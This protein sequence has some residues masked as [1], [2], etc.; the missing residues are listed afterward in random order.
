MRCSCKFRKWPNFGKI[1]IIMVAW[2]N[3]AW[4]NMFQQM[5]E[6]GIGCC[7]KDFIIISFHK[8]VQ[9]SFWLKIFAFFLFERFSVIF[10]M[11][12]WYFTL[13]MTILIILRQSSAEKIHSDFAKVIGCN[14]KTGLKVGVQPKMGIFWKIGAVFT[15]SARNAYP[16]SKRLFRN[17]FS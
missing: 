12:L 16:N 2:G 11:N 5:L 1:K 9:S 17:S 4:R 15:F 14:D 10:N 7:Q 8:D 3:I 6:H 13:N